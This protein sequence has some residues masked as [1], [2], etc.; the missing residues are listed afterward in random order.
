MSEVDAIIE[1]QPPRF[2]AVWLLPVAVVLIAAWVV[3]D[4]YLS[5]GQKRL[6]KN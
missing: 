5:D 1:D 4:S 6:R 3:A 2:Q